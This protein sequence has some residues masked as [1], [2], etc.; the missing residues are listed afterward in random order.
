[1]A[2]L[3]LLQI[4][5]DP[6]V[7]DFSPWP[8]QNAD[9]L[10]ER[11]AIAQ[12]ALRDAGFDVTECLVPDDVDAAESSVRRAFAGHEFDVVEVGSGLRASNDYTPV[13]ECVINTVVALAPGVR[14]SF[15]DSPET[16]LEAVLRSVQP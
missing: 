7:V 10:F 11:I 6:N 14:F 4:G 13:F 15:N 1:M 3:R 16:T 8:G 9:L 5:I 2:K 12:A